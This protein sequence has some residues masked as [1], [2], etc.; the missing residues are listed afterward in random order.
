MLVTQQV[1]SHNFQEMRRHFPRMTVWP[2]NLGDY[3]DAFRS[4]G[5]DVE[6]AHH[7][8]R[9]AYPSLGEVVYNLAVLPW[10]IEHFDVEA[11][12]DALLALEADCS[13][14]DGLVLTQCRCLITARRRG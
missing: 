7:D 4:L 2:D 10:E 5:F 12:L 3:S 14:A 1:Y 9:V 13:T 8:R 11:D 6:S